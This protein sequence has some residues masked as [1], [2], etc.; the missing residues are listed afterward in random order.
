M[1]QVAQQK[2]PD[3]FKVKSFELI[4]KNGRRRAWLKVDGHGVPDLTFFSKKGREKLV[5]GLMR[6]MNETE[7]VPGLYFYDQHEKR[8]ILLTLLHDGSPRLTFMDDKESVI[9]KAP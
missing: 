6:G 5:I 4:D 7:P 8:R 3:V 1:G 9:W 2:I